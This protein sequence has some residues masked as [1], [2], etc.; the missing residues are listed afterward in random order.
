MTSAI[1]GFDPSQVSTLMPYTDDK[2]T[3]PMTP[4]QLNVTDLFSNCPTTLLSTHSLYTYT[5]P[6]GDG[7]SYRCFPRLAIP[8]M[9]NEFG[10]PWWDNCVV[11][12]TDLGMVDPP[13]ALTYNGPLTP[14]STTDPS[15]IPTVPPVTT[16]LDP[17]LTPT[18]P[19]IS[20]TETS[21]HTKAPVPLSTSSPIT[22]V[23]KPGIPPDPPSTST[24][25][26]TDPG[27][28]SIQP[29]LSK[30]K[31]SDSQIVGNTEVVTG[32]LPGQWQ[33]PPTIIVVTIGTSIISSVL[34]NTAA[35]SVDPSPET[36]TGDGNAAI[37]SGA[38]T[39]VGDPPPLGSPILMTGGP[40]TIAYKDTTLTLGGASATVAYAGQTLTMGGNVVTISS[41][42]EVL[43]YGSAGIVAQLPGGG[44]STIPIQ[45]EI[46]ESTPGASTISPTAGGGP[47]ATIASLIY[48]IMK[49]GPSP[50]TTGSFSTYATATAPTTG[51]GNELP[52]G[53]ATNSASTETTG[54][55]APLSSVV[56]F[57]GSTQLGNHTI[58]ATGT[59]TGIGGS[60]SVQ[61]N[62]SGKIN[63]SSCWGLAALSFGVSIF[64]AGLAKPGV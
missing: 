53:S 40:Q 38:S 56:G 25:P 31:T 46:L 63:P 39:T 33:P 41:L 51:S 9:V 11:V 54:S 61:S 45:V 10:A 24:L 62:N 28:Q 34:E 32:S 35:V 27:Q 42:N 59:L 22:D 49:G 44:V 21:Q 8:T 5:H 14:F 18:K 60:A 43:S 6:V 29:N 17:I 12:N 57:A 4:G 26:A 13:S 15:A 16:L 52:T 30:S 2:E 36:V 3:G 7:P 64:A 37:V 47:A 48:W 58:V 55:V 23:S 19:L 20:I 50:S 1:H